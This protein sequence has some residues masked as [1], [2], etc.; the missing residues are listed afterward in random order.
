[1]TR[2][3]TMSR[4]RSAN[5]LRSLVV[6]LVTLSASFTVDVELFSWERRHWASSSIAAIIGKSGTL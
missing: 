5:A 4:K 2:E 1:M 3:P 6:L